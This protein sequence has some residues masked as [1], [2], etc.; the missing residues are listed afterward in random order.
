MPLGQNHGATNLLVGVAGVY[1]Q[2]DVDFHR[3]VELSRGG[4]DHQT[5]GIGGLYCTARSI[6]LALSLYFYL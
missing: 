4:L 2:L 1:T 5:Q 3:L 6:C